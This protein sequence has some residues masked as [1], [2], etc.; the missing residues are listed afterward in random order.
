MN[1]TGAGFFVFRCDPFISLSQSRIGLIFC[2]PLLTS[3]VIQSDFMFIQEAHSEL[4][5]S[6]HILFVHVSFCCATVLKLT[7]RHDNERDMMKGKAYSFEPDL[8][9]VLLGLST[10]CTW[11]STATCP[12]PEAR[13]GAMLAIALVLFSL[14]CPVAMHGSHLCFCINFVP[15]FDSAPLPNPSTPILSNHRLWHRCAKRR[16]AHDEIRWIS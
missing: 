2:F 13:E 16:Y 12:P 1:V 14:R 8:G 5:L 3:A 15:Y 7:T 4:H 10:A 9:D 11:L 6:S